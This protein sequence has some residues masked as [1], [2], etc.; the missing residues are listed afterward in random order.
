MG[1]NT[2]K[3]LAIM[4]LL[5]CLLSVAVANENCDIRR[6]NTPPY[7]AKDA[8]P[9]VGLNLPEYTGFCQMPAP[10]STKYTLLGDLCG[11]GWTRGFPIAGVDCMVGWRI[12]PPNVTV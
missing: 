10:D 9:K 7:Q 1:M 3:N 6:L 8:H 5:A 4:M 11:V 12:Q 2:K